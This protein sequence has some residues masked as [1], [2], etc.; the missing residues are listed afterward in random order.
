ML[1]LRCLYVTVNLRF[2]AVRRKWF[3]NEKDLQ[4]GDVVLVMSP[5]SPRSHWPLGKIIEVYHGKDGHVRVV[6]IQIGKKQLAR[7]ISKPCSLELQ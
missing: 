4:T 1:S 6:K 7:P 2:H 3:K 5:D